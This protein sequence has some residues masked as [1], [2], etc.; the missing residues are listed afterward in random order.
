[1]GNFSEKAS[2]TEAPLELAAVTETFSHFN[3][4]Q[5]LFQR[6]LNIVDLAVMI[7][8]FTPH[9]HYFMSIP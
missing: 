3:N 1:M 8:R 2:R 6:L 9:P 5:V 4:S 7:C